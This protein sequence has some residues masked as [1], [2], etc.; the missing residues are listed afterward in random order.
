MGR[1]ERGERRGGGRGEGEGG[2]G[3]E[4]E[5]GGEGGE[6]GRGRGRHS[7]VYIRFVKFSKLQGQCT[8]HTVLASLS[9]SPCLHEPNV[10]QPLR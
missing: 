4:G 1:G 10:L 2:R 6:E 9:L 3:G 7:C 5:G 8:C